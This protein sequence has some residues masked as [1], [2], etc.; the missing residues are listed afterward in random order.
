MGEITIF[1]FQ[2]ETA[3]REGIRNAHNRINFNDQWAFAFFF[4]SLK[5]KGYFA[6]GEPNTRNQLVCPREK[7]A[8]KVGRVSARTFSSSLLRL[9]H[10]LLGSAPLLAFF[11]CLLLLASSPRQ[12]LN[13]I[14]LSS[15]GLCICCSG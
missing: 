9:L 10:F 7:K 1:N 2:H 5:K 3:G 11:F 13:F 8:Q 4:S 12:L 6:Y 15:T 14:N